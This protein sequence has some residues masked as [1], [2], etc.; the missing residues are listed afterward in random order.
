VAELLRLPVRQRTVVVLRFY[1]DLPLTDIARLLDRPAGTVRSDLHR[2]LESL[3]RTL[4]GHRHQ[5]R[6]RR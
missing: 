3:P 1:E 2:A 6:R 4:R 5:P